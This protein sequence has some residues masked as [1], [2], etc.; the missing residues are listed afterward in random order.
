M[1]LIGFSVSEAWNNLCLLIDG[2]IY[3]MVSFS[4]RVFL[5]LANSSPFN[6]EDY[7]VIIM[8]IYVLLGIIMTFVMTYEL[9]MLIIDPDGSKKE[10][11]P[12]K[13]IVNLVVSIAILV[14]LPSFFGFLSGFQNSLLNKDFLGHLI[15]GTDYEESTSDSNTCDGNSNTI[16]RGGNLMASEVFSAFFV[17]QGSN[18]DSTITASATFV[19]YAS[20][21]GEEVKESRTLA[22]AKSCFASHGNFSPFNNFLDNVEKNEISFNTIFSMLA[23][24]VL[25]YVIISFCFDLGIRVVKLAFLQLIAPI[26]VIMR[27]IPKSKDVFNNWLKMLFSVYLEVFVRIGSMYIGVLFITLLSKHKDWLSGCETNNFIILLAKAFVIMGIVACIKIIPDMLKKLFPGM[28]SGG[29]KLGIKD[30]LAASGAFA[31]GAGVGAMTTTGVRNFNANK[32]K[33]FDKRL[34]SGIAGAGSGLARGVKGGA[35]AKNW[36]DMNKAASAATSAATGK[37]S[38]RAAYKASHGG[39]IGGVI[40]GHVSDTWDSIQKWSGKNNIEELQGANA[41]IDGLLTKKSALRNAAE[42]AIV[43]ESNK[44]GA[45][46]SFGLGNSAFR[47]QY[48]NGDGSWSVKMA[49]V[50]SD[51][52]RQK[53][54]ALDAAKASGDQSQLVTAENEYNA[55]LKMATDQIQNQALHGETGWAAINSGDRADMMDVR[56]A[57]EDYRNELKRHLNAGFVTEANATATGTKLDSTTIGGDLNVDSNSAMGTIGNALKNAKTENY[58]QISK[59]QQKEK[60]KSDDSGS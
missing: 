20:E 44:P 6:Y 51:I 60:D 50:N 2:A 37:R 8:R 48:K 16:R 15:L 52:L 34:I 31:V 27:I 28:D 19:C 40:A 12:G 36:A 26:P 54:Q 55:Y 11:N 14:L 45:Q 22:D 32:G 9:F 41:V 59:I 53:R 56:N 43:N 35:G 24:L 25:C 7:K 29:M 42:T 47:Y 4:Y 33:G 58:A 3:S 10:S 18:T 23:G 30:K 39:N 46:K 57:A 5:L 49:Q 17:A 21:N 13:F 38:A 1:L